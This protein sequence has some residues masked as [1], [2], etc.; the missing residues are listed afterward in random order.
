MTSPDTTVD[1]QAV[2]DF[3]YLEAR[4]ADEGR[5]E[6]WEAL[7]TDDGL[8]WIPAG[9]DDPDPQRQLSFAYDNRARIASRV[10]QLLAGTH[11]TQVPPSRTRRLIGNIELL[12]RS[13]D[14]LTVG[15]NFLLTEYRRGT[16]TLWS[17]RTLHGLRPES[18]AF[19]MAY[20]KVL[21]VNNTG[22]IPTMSFLI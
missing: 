2:A 6:E 17:G 14:Q 3:L 13:G 1:R 15:S 4:L 8:Y 21:L 16:L 20:K 7:W 9:G 18:G 19:R 10:R 11:H 12:D 5:Y 22:D